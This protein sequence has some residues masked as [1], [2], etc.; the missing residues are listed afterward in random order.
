MDAGDHPALVPGR[1]AS[2]RAGA[3]VVGFVGQVAPALAAAHG[4]PDDDPLFV[5]EFDLSGAGASAV[6]TTRIEPLPRHPSVTRD[7]SI[8]IP[9]TVA[10]RAIRQTVWDSAPATLADVREFDRYQGQGVGDGQVSLSLHLT[11]RA[12]DRTLTDGEVQDAMAH[13]IGAL[14]QA[15]GAVQR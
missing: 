13:I 4:L 12:A 5:A 8:L 14:S 7:V 3:E 1:S 10:A 11:F 9:D 2:V 6:M 15:H